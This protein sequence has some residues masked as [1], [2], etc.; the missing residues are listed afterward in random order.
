MKD[1]KR[2]A[3]GRLKS[4]WLL[5]INMLKIGLFTFGGG[6]AIIHLLENEFVSKKKWIEE[7]EFMDL[8][9]I[10][11]STPG[12]IAINCSTYIGYK[13]EKILGAVLATLGMCIPS[14]TIIFL[15]SLFFN[16]FLSI[17]WVASAFKGIQVCV[18][19][20]IL[21]AGVKML[22]KMKKKPFNLIVM[23]ATFLWMVAFGVF[24][25]SFSSIFYILIS[26]FVGLLIYLIGYFKSKKSP[27]KKEGE[28]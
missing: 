6:Y 23:S 15:I 25:V 7:D 28:Q 17:G 19:F 4:L 5:F 22:K 18:V 14:F 1:E 10:A 3:T 27:E 21:S 2:N 24:A 13:K 16:Q 9:A 20:L 8:V 12:P 26:G 11:E